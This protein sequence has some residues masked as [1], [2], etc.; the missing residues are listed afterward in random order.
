MMH[1][2]MHAPP[3]PRPARAEQATSTTPLPTSQTGRADV[4][5]Y[6]PLPTHPAHQNAHRF[7]AADE[8]LEGYPLPG[9]P[10]PPRLPATPLAWMV[11][12]WALPEE[13]VGR[14]GVWGAQH[15]R[16]GRPVFTPCSR[17]PAC[18]V[19]SMHACT[20]AG[21]GGGGVNAC[22]HRAGR[23]AHGHSLAL[24]TAAGP[25]NTSL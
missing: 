11:P 18:K 1:A 22:A 8:K 9:A 3:P 19:A 10:K 12:V 21:G 7:E 24:P 13:Q 2:C 25:T 14:W 4:K 23:A 5:P 17:A 15:S 20:R 16:H 6:H